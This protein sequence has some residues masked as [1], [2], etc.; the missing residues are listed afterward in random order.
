MATLIATLGFDWSHV[1][2][3]FNRSNA[4]KVVLLTTNASHPRVKSALDELS[5]F[6]KRVGFEVVVKEVNV[7]DFWECVGELADVLINER[8]VYLDIGG[9]V[10]A[11]SLCA[12]ISAMLAIQLSEVRVVKVFTQ[13]E[14]IEKIV[15]VDL[16]PLL[17]ASKFA[18]LRARRKREILQGDSLEGKYDRRL[19]KELA[20]YGIM[21]GGALTTAGKAIA[22]FLKREEES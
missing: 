4:S 16:R 15:E 13:A 9:G 22:K 20:E 2:A 12:L 21:N 8:V 7:E 14:H 10:R 3:A 18:D 11:L 1:I 19:A 5:L 6:S 17:Y